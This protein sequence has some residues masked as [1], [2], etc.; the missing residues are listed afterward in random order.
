MVEGDKV[1]A[2][3]V[4]T[5]EVPGEPP[6]VVEI[7]GTL[8]EPAAF[9][10]LVVDGLHFLCHCVQKVVLGTLKPTVKPWETSESLSIAA[11]WPNVN[12][13]MLPWL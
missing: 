8:A 5:V 7:G 11:T 4:N 10:P 2:V 1:A 6:V 9:S 13:V 3:T 12:D